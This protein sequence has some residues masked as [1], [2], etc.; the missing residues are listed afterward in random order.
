MF[1]TAHWWLQIGSAVRQDMAGC[2]CH[3]SKR[4]WSGND[5]CLQ[6]VCKEHLEQDSHG[7]GYAAHHKLA[8]VVDP[9]LCFMREREREKKKKTQPTGT[10]QYCTVW[11][12]SPLKPTAPALPRT[13]NS[14][15]PSTAYGASG[16]LPVTR[17]VSIFSAS[18]R[19]VGS[20]HERLK[21]C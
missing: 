12:T 18:A 1:W 7:L 3:I 8:N 6:L 2:M 19:E 13:T 14:K 21:P 17:K 4:N 15:P 10:A 11:A 9:F 16:L 20:S 5:T